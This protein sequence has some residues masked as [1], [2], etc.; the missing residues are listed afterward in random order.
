[1]AI[2]EAEKEVLAYSNHSSAV[3]T[4]NLTCGGRF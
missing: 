2:Y 4:R 3:I 1:M